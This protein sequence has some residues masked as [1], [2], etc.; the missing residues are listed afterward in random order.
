MTDRVELK[1]EARSHDPVFRRAIR[2]A[3]I[4]AFRNAAGEVRSI[5]GTAGKA[6][7]EYRQD[8]E[9]FRLP[10]NYPSIQAAAAA[11]AKAGASRF[12]L[13]PTAGWMPIGCRPAAFRPSR[14]A[15]GN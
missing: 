6:T 2:D 5:T 14:S 1:A 15:A 7:C 8:Y 4:E 11:V 9:S 12:N 10:D 13:F 3:I